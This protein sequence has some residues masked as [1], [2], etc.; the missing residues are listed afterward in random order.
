MVVKFPV[1]QFRLLLYSLKLFN[2]YLL[3][4]CMKNWWGWSEYRFVGF[5]YFGND[6]QQVLEALVCAL[7]VSSG[8]AEQ[9]RAVVWISGSAPDPPTCSL[10]LPP[11]LPKVWPYR[12]NKTRGLNIGTTWVSPRM[13]HFWKV[14]KAVNNFFLHSCGMVSFEWDMGKTPLLPNYIISSKRRY[15]RHVSI[16]FS[17]QQDGLV[18]WLLFVCSVIASVVSTF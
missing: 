10:Y 15:K 1:V 12:P 17:S 16:S 14:L 8:G 9:S 6:Q 3:S 18:D 2:E 5:R 7:N 4:E 13:S 11:V